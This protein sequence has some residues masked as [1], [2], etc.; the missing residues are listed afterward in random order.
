[1]DTIWVDRCRSCGGIWFDG[2]EMTEALRTFSLEKMPD[3]PEVKLPPKD[4]ACPCP[5]CNH[6]MEV[7]RSLSVPDVVYERCE[8]CGGVWFD[9]GEAEHFGDTDVAWLAL[10]L[11]EFG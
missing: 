3:P 6:V 4:Q 9:A 2:G 1:M 7:T 10:M 8:D 5:R 11:H